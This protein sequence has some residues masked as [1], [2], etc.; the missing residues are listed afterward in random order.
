MF[1]LEVY[2]VFLLQLEVLH[3]EIRWC[4]KILFRS[5]MSADDS[6]LSLLCV[7]NTGRAACTPPPL[8]HLYWLMLALSSSFLL[9][10]STHT[11]T[12]RPKHTLRQTG[13]QQKQ[14]H[15]LGWDNFPLCFFS[16]NYNL[17]FYWCYSKMK[18]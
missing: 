13:F 2:L 6:M 18:L 15:N 11:H 16:D 3:S 8:A 1:L 5:L 4:N 17:F 10:L 7:T 9:T 14:K 12:H